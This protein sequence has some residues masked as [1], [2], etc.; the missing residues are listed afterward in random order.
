M[1]SNMVTNIVSKIWMR[2]QYKQQLNNISF[3][4][5]RGI[6]DRGKLILYQVEE[7][8]KLVLN[9]TRLFITQAPQ[10]LVL[11]VLQNIHFF[12]QTGN[13]VLICFFQQIFQLLN[14]RSC[15][16]I[17]IALLARIAT[18]PE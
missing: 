16:Y 17:S 11:L 2:S 14:C 6:H 4:A 15:V 9:K 5:F 3:S 1:L 18:V 7:S 12:H 8:M 10:I 13:F